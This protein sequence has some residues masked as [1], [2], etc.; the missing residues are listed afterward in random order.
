[1][2][3]LK[4]TAYLIYRKARKDIPY[5][6]A[7][8]ALTFLIDMHLLLLLSLTNSL[9]IIT[10]YFS[11]NNWKD[12]ILACVVGLPTF[13]ML[14]FLIKENKLRQL[15]YSEEKIKKGNIF[16]VADFIVTFILLIII[17]ELKRK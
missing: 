13:L 9:N 8:C 5:L 12:Y 11:D 4:F 14:Y 3:T 10:R 15:N 17:S 1:M 7:L 2:E 6:S 16:L